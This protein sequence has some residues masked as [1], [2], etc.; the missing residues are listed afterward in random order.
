MTYGEVKGIEM[1]ILT[2]FRA[3]EAQEIAANLEG[4]LEYGVETRAEYLAMLSEDYDV[5]LDTVHALADV[6]GPMEDFD[7]LVT[8]LEDM[9]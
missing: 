8:S 2:S 5:D 6:L 7:G 4:Y 3:I 1:N 9:A